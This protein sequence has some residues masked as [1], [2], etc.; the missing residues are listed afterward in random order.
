[1]IKNWAM[2]VCVAVAGL[3]VAVN[4]AAQNGFGAESAAAFQSECAASGGGAELCTCVWNGIQQGMSGAEYQALDA[5][6]RSQQL[7]P[8]MAKYELI[9]GVCNG[10]S[11]VTASNP[12][13][14]PGHTS[15]NFMNGCQQG[16]VSHAICACSM[17]EIERTLTLQQFTE[18]DRM[19]SWGK[20]EE[21]ALYPN[22]ISIVQTCARNNQ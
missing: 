18:L 21:H 10:T 2:A 3:V 12:A 16:G 9:V 8:S 20:G 11:R 15:T 14:Y 7:H 17:N 6:L 22:F 13:A 1:M 4:A 5:A 19:M